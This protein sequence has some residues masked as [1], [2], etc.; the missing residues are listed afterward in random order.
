MI[1]KELVDEQRKSVAKVNRAA[2]AMQ[3]ANDALGKATDVYL[4]ATEEL[5]HIQKQINNILDGIPQE[6]DVIQ[7]KDP[8]SVFPD[9]DGSQFTPETSQPE[10]QSTLHTDQETGQSGYEEPEQKDD[11]THVRKE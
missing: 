5:K 3:K 6:K 9:N 11:V 1:P 8:K 7:S 4:K 10:E 2:E